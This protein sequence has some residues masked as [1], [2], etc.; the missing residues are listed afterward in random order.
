MSWDYK[1][2]GLATGN[3]QTSSVAKI[4]KDMLMGMTFTSSF[5]EVTF[6]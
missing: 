4:E 5:P 1:I 2:D 3:C 6:G